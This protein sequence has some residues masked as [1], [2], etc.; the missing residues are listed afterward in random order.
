LIWNAVGLILAYVTLSR[1]RAGQPEWFLTLFVIAFVLLGAWGMYYFLRELR[2]ATGIGPTT[3][4]ISDLPLIPGRRYQI[5]LLQRGRHVIRSLTVSLVCEEEAIFHQGTNVR[6]ERRVVARQPVFR[7]ENVAAGPITPFERQSSLD[8]PR[9]AMHSFQ[10]PHNA[11][12]WK[13]LVQGEAEGWPPFERCF[14]LL[15]YPAQ[16]EES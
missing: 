1:H 10:S 4:E 11:V 2:R 15:L 5:W 9:N 16:T 12:H 7:C 14:P 8:A 13:L 6:A 3:M